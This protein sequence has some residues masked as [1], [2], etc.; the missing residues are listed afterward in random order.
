MLFDY[1]YYVSFVFTSLSIK[2]GDIILHMSSNKSSEKSQATEQGAEGRAHQ[3]PMEV[4]T[5]K[6]FN[7]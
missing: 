1:L 2:L 4:Q 3:C 7:L 5:S 6:Q